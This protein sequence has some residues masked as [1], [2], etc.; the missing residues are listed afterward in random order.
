MDT[1]HNRNLLIKAASS[2]DDFDEWFPLDLLSDELSN[3]G[4]ELKT[5]GYSRLL[6]FVLQQPDLFK[7]KMDPESKKNPTFFVTF[8]GKPVI[9]NAPDEPSQVLIE[10]RYL[11]AN[12]RPISIDSEKVLE[13]IASN[14]K[15]DAKLEASQNYFYHLQ[16]V[17][18]ILNKS[19]YYIIGRKGSGKSSISEYLFSLKNHDTF[20]EKLSFKNFPFN[21]LYDLGNPKFT[22]PNQYITLWKYLIY[23]TVAKLMVQNEKINSSIREQLGK[24]YTPDPI[25]SLSRT[26]TQWTS[27]EFGANIL[28]AG[29]VI[30]FSRDSKGQE[31]S[32]IERVNNLE[33]IISNHCDG[34][35]YFIIFDELDEDYR[36]I[37]TSEHELYNYLLTSLFKAVQDIKYTFNSSN[38]SICPVVFL[39]DDIYSLVKDADKNKWRDFKIEI[40]WNTEKIKRLIAHRISRDAGLTEN[41]TFNDAWNLIF[42]KPN[43]ISGSKRRMLN[44]FDYITRST[45]LRPRDYIRFIQVCAEETVAFGRNKIANETI[46]YV[47][48][49]FSNYLKDE[50]VDEIYPIL[51]DIEEILQII[52]NLRKWLFRSEEFKREYLKYLR[53]KTISEENVDYV[54][55]TLYRFSVIGNQSKFKRDTIY[56]KYLHTNMNI[57]KNEMLVL[58]RGLFKALQII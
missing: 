56:F 5:T 51:P 43:I 20:T 9:L 49:A 17:N 32:W 7:L 4:F 8:I 29:G 30:K 40:D 50:I 52:S 14:W 57:N 10:S 55:D 24:I 37:R 47:D 34:S 38:L 18:S 28:G 6:D 33:D 19:K 27:K 11:N 44:S 41:L 26:I 31:A 25:R 54:L 13:S 45:H 16:E 2:I 35:K 23:S 3:L 21:E 12:S 46:K 15:L 53:T 42:Y 22:P 1:N 58:H 36:T 39:R 48:R